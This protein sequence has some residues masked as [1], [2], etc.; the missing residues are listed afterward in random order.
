MRNLTLLTAF[1]IL[2]A[3]ITGFP[4]NAQDK[5]S[6]TAQQSDLM[7]EF[8]GKWEATG[9]SFGLPSKSEMTWT[10]DLAGKFYRIEFRIDMERDEKTQTFLGHGY[11]RKGSTDGFWADTGG[12]LHPMV[13]NYTEYALNTIWGEAGGKQGRSRYELT[14]DGD[15]EVTDWVLQESGWREFNRTLFRRAN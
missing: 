14:K 11:Y 2:A 13:T 4:V 3:S 10:E 6:P 12:D 15:I 1:L 7:K 8:A 9:T 5:P